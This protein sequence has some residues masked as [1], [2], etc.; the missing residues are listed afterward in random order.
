MRL[1]RGQQHTALSYPPISHPSVNQRDAP[2]YRRSCTVSSL[3]FFTTQPN[4]LIVEITVGRVE[5]METH[6]RVQGRTS[7]DTFYCEPIIPV[8]TEIV[9]RRPGSLGD[10]SSDVRN[11]RGNMKTDAGGELAGQPTEGYVSLRLS[12]V[13]LIARTLTERK[14]VR[15]RN[16]SISA[17]NSINFTKR[18]PRSTI[19]SL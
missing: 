6:P 3:V 1:H 17:E 19:R 2:H 14:R 16:R 5:Q 15:C 12:L 13:V 10:E 18:R 7:G 4:R 11:P 8:G 9:F